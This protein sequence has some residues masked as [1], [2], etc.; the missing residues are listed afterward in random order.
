MKRIIRPG[1]E[2]HVVGVN[3][4][5]VEHARRCSAIAFHL[6]G[7]RF[8]GAFDPAAPGQSVLAEQDGDRAKRGFPRTARRALEALQ[9]AVHRVPVRR[10]A[11]DHLSNVGFEGKNTRRR[12]DD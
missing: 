5:D 12:D 6:V 2:R 7:A 10:D 3:R 9:P 4:A 1:G 11:D 8:G